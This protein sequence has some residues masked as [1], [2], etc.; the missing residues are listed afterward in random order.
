MTTRI[1]LDISPSF[2]G[3]AIPLDELIQ[4]LL[5]LK[6]MSEGDRLM[7]FEPKQKRREIVIPDE[8]M[9]LAAFE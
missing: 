6:R 7:S 9:R 5:I 3:E 4:D 8:R 2:D 1:T